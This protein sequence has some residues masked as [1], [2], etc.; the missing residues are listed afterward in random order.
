VLLY[1][2]TFALTSNV[3]FLIGS[4]MADRFLFLPSLGFALAL[5]YLA[6]RF[7]KAED[8][9]LAVGALCVV[10]SLQTM[11]RTGDWKSDATLFTADVGTSA[12]SGR[13]HRNF[14]T[15]LMNSAF[16]TPEQ[17]RKK[18]LLDVAYDQ[19]SICTVID[20]LD[21]DAHFAL[22]Q[23]EYQ[24]GHYESSARSTSR[25]LDTYRHLGAT[26][27]TQLHL[28]LGDAMMR[29]SRYD[30][31]LNEFTIAQRTT[32][33]D[34]TLAIRIGNTKF[35]K[36]DLDGAI[37]SFETAVHLNPSSIQAWD[38]LANASG[39]KGNAARS[40]EAFRMI[41]KLKNPSATIDT[42]GRPGLKPEPLPR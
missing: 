3:F 31:A 39:M 36:N 27:P 6:V 20:P 38:K 34:A 26:P 25:A 13:V 19:F 14:A 1:F 2:V 30:E 41:E 28:N 15:L 23:V 4:T 18:R 35:A 21:Y 12:G 40:A 5:A 37:E 32:P 9:V 11:S 17:G 16:E 22:G 29:L 7:F 33:D 10:Y 24:R 8:L 42:S